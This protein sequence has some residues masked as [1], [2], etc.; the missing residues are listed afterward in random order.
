MPSANLHPTSRSIHLLLHCLPPTFIP[1]P[2][3][4][5]YCSIA[6]PQPLSLLQIHTSPT[7]LAF[8]QP[9]SLLQI[10]TSPAPSPFA[11]LHPSSRSIHFLHNW[12]S[13]NLH[14][15]SRSLHLLLRRIPPPF[16]SPPDPCIS[17][18]IAFLHHSSLLQ[19]HTYPFQSPSSTIHPSSRS[20]HLL[21]HRLPP[22]FIPPPD[23]YIS[24]SIAFLLPASSP[25]SN[26]YPSSTSILLLFNRFP[27]PFIPPPD[28]YISCSIAFLHT[29]S[30][31]QIRTSLLHRLR[32]PFIPPP[33]PYISYTIG[34]PPTF[35]PHPDPHISCSIAFLHLSYLLQ[36]HI[37]PVQSPSSILHSSSRSIHILFRR[38][39]PPFIPPPDPYI[40][41]S[42]AFLHH[43][44]HLQIHTSPAPSPSSTIHPS[45]R[46]IP[47]C[48]IA[49]VH[50][51]SLLQIHSSPA[52][53]PSST[54]HPSSS[55]IH[56]LF[57]RLPPLFIP[58]PDPYISCSIAFLHHSSLFQIHT[59]P[60][61]SPS[62]TLLPSSRSI[63]LL[64]NRLPPP[65]IPP[66]DPYISCSIAFLNPSSLLQIDT[67]PVQSPSSTIHPSSRSIHLLL[68]RLPQPFIPPPDRYISCSVA[69]LH[70]SSLLQI[71]ISP[72]P[73]PSSTLHTSSR[74]IH[75][76]VHRLPPPFIPPPD[77]YIS[78]SIAFLHPSS[79]L[80]IHTSPV[81]SPYSTF[82]PSSRS[83]HL[84]VHRL[85]PPFIPPPDPY[86][87]C[88]IAF[89]HPSSL[90][91]IHTSPAPSPSSTL[92][93]SS[94][95]IHLLFSRLPPPFIP[96][97][98]PYISCSIAFLHPSYLLQI[99]T[100][101]G[102]SPSSTLH[103]SSRSIH[104]LLHRLPPPFFPPPD[105]YI[106]CFIA[107][108]HL[109]PLLE[110]HTSPV[111][112]PS[113]TLHPSSRSIHLLLHRLPPPVIPPPDP[114]IYCSIVFLHP[115]SIVQI[116][117]SP[118]PSPS[119]ILY[120][121]SRS[122]ISCSIAF[123]HTSSLLQI[124]T[125]PAP[126]PSSIL[127]PSSR[128]I[129]SCSIAF[130]HT[131]SL[132]QIH[133]SPA[134]SPSSS[135]HPSSRSIRLLLHRLPPIFD[136]PPDPYISC[137]I[138]FLHPSYLLQIHI[139]PVQS[140]SSTLHT[141]SRTTHL[142]INSLRPPFIPLPDPYISCS[143]AFLHHSSLLQIH[144]SPVQSPS[145]TLHP[146]SSS[147]HLL[148]QCFFT[149]HVCILRHDTSS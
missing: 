149:E 38:L 8:L 70:H 132:L 63:H 69:F 6:I 4:Y 108:L 27:P 59:S 32:P 138:A 31:L 114:Y 54:L 80:Q 78:C 25:S 120:P 130:L 73:S 129:I 64:F 71:H 68:H 143:T 40:S 18:S 104:L 105:P 89:L 107:L 84:L 26:L 36:I 75:L 85:P 94:R 28:P 11:N 10:H 2:D 77:P 60:A 133:T 39:P 93:P 57:S 35:I 124:H 88:S 147:I 111:P 1:P 24:C 61:P 3:P 49:F 122:I 29:S 9:S 145:S 34:L 117:T 121:S 14:P 82:H 131:S 148:P 19:I 7:Q 97:P 5:I 92:H 50:P 134:P 119:S 115:S 55:S 23:T 22:T 51:S 33:D 112:S 113:S 137:S 110:I 52:P 45:S 16:T 126:S 102:P 79:L 37:S 136:P 47:L 66:P 90:L 13:S 98:D 146:S 67:S 91:Q 48:S 56:L 125:S 20:I 106:S 140:P 81:S 72:A 103:P 116:H 139:C 128:S 135:I 53:S 87:S 101:P 100:S 62:S 44:P 46:S 127:Y 15:T 43:S 83:I 99:H 144:T 123:L 141:S 30:L 95:S 58:P 21:L 65:F 142:L 118:A 74:S 41:F 17:C 12:P 76:L 42:N 109:S 96:P 86:I